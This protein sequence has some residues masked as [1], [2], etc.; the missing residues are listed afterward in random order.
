M[1]IDSV[2]TCTAEFIAFMIVGPLIRC[3]GH[4]G[5]MYMGLV[6]YGIRFCV[7]A[8]IND[9]WLVLPADILQG[10]VD[11][12]SICPNIIMFLFLV[13]CHF[14]LHLGFPDCLHSSI[15]SF[16]V[17]RHGPRDLTRS[18]LRFG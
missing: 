5:V 10:W 13:R 8:V 6:G 2:V 9:P 12:I 16:S 15:R 1:G 14:L 17:T 4:M 7:Y 3:L 11:I 18:L